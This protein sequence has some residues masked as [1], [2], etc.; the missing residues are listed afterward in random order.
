[1]NNT[2]EPQLTDVAL[3][4]MKKEGDSLFLLLAAP[5]YVLLDTIL[6]F[7]NCMISFKKGKN[8][9]KKQF[10]KKQEEVHLT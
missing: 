3:T 4:Y 1:M 9:A 5:F 6:R 8:P 7:I 10:K 2:T